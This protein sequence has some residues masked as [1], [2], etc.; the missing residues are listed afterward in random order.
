[1]IPFVPPPTPTAPWYRRTADGL[2]HP[3]RWV[4]DL[5]GA[6]PVKPLLILFGLNAV[7]ELART[8][9]SVT[10]PTIADAFDVGIVGVAVPFVLAFAV[11]LA[12]SVPIASVADRGNRVRLA[13]IGGLVFALFSTLVG[14]SVSIWM[15]ALMLAGSQI[16]K[17]FIEP[18]HTSLLADYYE[19]GLRPRI[20]SFYR[21]GNALG[22]LIGGVGAGYVA[23]AFSW[24]APFFFFAVPTLLLVLAGA[25]LPEPRR[26]VQEKK[27]AGAAP[28]AIDVEEPAPSM[29]EAWRMCWQIDSLRR[30][31]R[32]LPFLTP[33]I[34]GFAIFS[35]FL[36]RDVFGLDDTARVGWSASSRA[37]PS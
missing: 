23:E 30:I 25:T 32:V 7:D 2:R 36:Y 19:V 35:T 33:A 15:V 31:Y 17:A 22:A 14:L 11:A 21:S 1:V 16:G 4:D 18:S 10:A 37:R 6:G 3:V 12:L 8:S 28:T 34:A 24:R 27:L 9:F 20:F 26:G 29:T 5:T 13:L